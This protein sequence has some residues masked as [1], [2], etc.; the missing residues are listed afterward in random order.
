MR[1]ER[2]DLSSGTTSVTYAYG[3]TSVAAEDA[4]PKQLLAWNRGHW[5]VESKNHQR[6][7]KTLDEDACL[8]RTGLAPANRATCNNLVLALILN[9]RQWHNAAAALRHFTLHRKLAL[10]AVL[11]P[12]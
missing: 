9:R 11:S 10:Q 12:A 4:S 8:A 1:R 2:T 5:A 3:I 6:R 7:D